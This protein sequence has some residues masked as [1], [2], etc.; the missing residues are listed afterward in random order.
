MPIYNIKGNLLDTHCQYICHQVNCQG[1]MNSGIA[2]SIRDKWPIVYENYMAKYNE[3][4]RIAAED[5]G[6]YENGP[7]AADLLLGTVQFV[8]LYENYNTS[9]KHNQ[10]INMFCQ[11]GYGYDG[12]RY[13]SYDAFWNALN[14]IQGSIDPGST[15]AFPKNIGCCRGGA[16]WAVISNMIEVVLGKDYEVFIYSLED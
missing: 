6:C 7:D 14:I 10:V 12:K 11:Y 15:I 9:I 2:K 4:Q 3:A 8:P 13:T 1:K 5:Y 16:N